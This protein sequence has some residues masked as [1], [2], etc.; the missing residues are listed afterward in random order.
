MY[1]FL[2]TNGRKVIFSILIMIV[3]LIVASPDV[4]NFVGSIVGLD[5]YDNP[6]MED[7]YDLLYIHSFVM[8]LLTFL[9]LFIYIYS[10]N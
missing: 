9:M 6:N 10:L 1:D 5:N 2:R 8:A 4:Y 3:Y 7:R